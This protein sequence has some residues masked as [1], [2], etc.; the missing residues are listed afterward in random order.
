MVFLTP[1]DKYKRRGYQPI[2]AEIVRI[3]WRC[4]GVIQL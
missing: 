2:A 4:T 3:L 1:P